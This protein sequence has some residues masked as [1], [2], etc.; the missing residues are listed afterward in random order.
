MTCYL[1]LRCPLLPRPVAL[2]LR[3][4][5]AAETVAS[6][7]REKK[8]KARLLDANPCRKG[9]VRATRRRQAL[10]PHVVTKLR[11]AHTMVASLHGPPSPF[12][13]PAI[14]V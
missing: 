12:S 3:L 8:S 14:T 4:L 5:L 2:S 1:R 11:V 9:A 6:A 7:G 13:T 10:P